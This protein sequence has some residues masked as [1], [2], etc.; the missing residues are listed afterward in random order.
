MHTHTHTQTLNEAGIAKQ[1]NK[2]TVV[3]LI[4]VFLK[5][6]SKKRINIK[7]HCLEIVAQ[8]WI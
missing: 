4:E 8:G 1:T 3:F 2:K 6:F 5:N 7:I